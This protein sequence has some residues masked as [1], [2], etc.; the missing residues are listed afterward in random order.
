MGESISLM[1]IVLL[2]GRPNIVFGSLVDHI[3]DIELDSSFIVVPF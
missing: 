3:F 2:L 1:L